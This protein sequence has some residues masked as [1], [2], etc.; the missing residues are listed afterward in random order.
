MINI[1]K[2]VA[3]DMLLHGTRF[4]LAEFAFGVLCPLLLFVLFLRAKLLGGDEPL[5][6]TLMDCWLIGIA[7]NY[8]PLFIYAVM[9]ARKGSV[10]EEGQPERASVIKYSI[11][12]F[13]IFIPLL[14]ALI[15]F[16]QENRRQR[17]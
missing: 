17:E 3:L 9:I 16:I 13:I 4:I 14:V 10:A 2:L 5:W 12:Q 1:R 15:A 8:I 6:V 7:I 11:Q